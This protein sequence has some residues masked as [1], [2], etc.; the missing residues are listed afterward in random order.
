MKKILLCITI[1]IL[2]FELC[3]S[4]TLNKS[5]RTKYGEFRYTETDQ[6]TIKDLLKCCDKE[7]PSI[8]SQLNI[9][10]DLE[11]VIEIY[12]NQEEYNKYIINPSSK[13]SPA[14]SGNG[15][16]Q[17]I[18]PL[19]SL[20][21]EKKVGVFSY[22][23]KLYFLIHEY[24]H[25]LINKISETVPICINEGAASYL[26]SYDF[27]MKMAQKYVRQ[28]NFIPSVEQLISNYYELP[29]ADLFSFLLIDFMVTGKDAVALSDL[30]RHP[31]LIRSRNEGWIDY[32]KGKYY[33]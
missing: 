26:S 22:E 16:I 24:A 9:E 11:L 17:I 30:I 25:V 19:A 21:A 4:N 3:F 23:E 14:I 29:A 10:F 12:P 33:Q 27:Y 6:N 18:S 2:F 28:L 32:I 1:I 7:I 20:A 31:E 13:N 15:I 8:C 5:L